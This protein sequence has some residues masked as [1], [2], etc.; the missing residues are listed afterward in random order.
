MVGVG[1]KVARIL[2]GLEKHRQKAGE[3][4]HSQTSSIRAEKL[5]A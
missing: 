3:D 1:D 5:D 2:D 4:P